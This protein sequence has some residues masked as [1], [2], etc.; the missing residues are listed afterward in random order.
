MA[1]CVIPAEAGTTNEQLKGVAKVKPLSELAVNP[2]TEI[3]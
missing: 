1:A 3:P 2:L